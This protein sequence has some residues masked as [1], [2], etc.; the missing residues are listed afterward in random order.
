VDITDFTYPGPKPQ[1]RETAILMLADGC[2]AAVRSRQPKNKT[3]ILETVQSVIEGKRKSGQLDESNLTLHDLKT[4]QN[5]FIEMFQAIYHP[6]IN[7]TEAIERV[8][9]GNVPPSANDAPPA[10]SNNTVA[11]KPST[12][13]VKTSTSTFPAVALPRSADDDDDDSPLAEVPRLR[14]TEENGVSE[15]ELNDADRDSQ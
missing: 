12:P 3:E 10:D 7:Y 8:R 9:K 2:E 6:R 14:R 13:A 1:T 11:T 4:I 5:I 15:S